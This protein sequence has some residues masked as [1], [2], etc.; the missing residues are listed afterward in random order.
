[1]KQLENNQLLMLSILM[2]SDY[3]KSGDTV[4]KIVCRIESDLNR[5]KSVNASRMKPSEWRRLVD[6][7]KNQSDLLLYSVQHLEGNFNS[8]KNVACFVDNPVNPQDVNIVF[9]GTHKKDELLDNGMGCYQTD[10]Q[11]QIE[12]AEYVNKLPENYG[13]N[14]TVTGHSKGG[15]KAQYVTVTTDRIGRCVPFDSQGFSKAFFEKY[16]DE[17]S[18]KSHCITA[19]NAADDYVNSI[20]IPIPCKRIFL[21]SNINY[22]YHFIEFHKPNIMLDEYGKLNP[23]QKRSK[24]SKQVSK[25]S[26]YL[27][28][29]RDKFGEDSDIDKLVVIV[30][31]ICS[32]HTKLSRH[33]FQPLWDFFIVFF[34][35]FVLFPI[36]MPACFFKGLRLVLSYVGANIK[37]LR[38]RRYNLDSSID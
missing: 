12:A 6:I 4:Q 9:R 37:F 7:I 25:Y 15:N 21:K 27:L 2:Y 36:K 28:S 3:I 33:F 30:E 24:F 35:L 14:M 22:V 19:I 8:G 29:N 34:G 23:V 18:K 10:T 13:N 1:M 20:F 26:A 16:A 31:K 5:G 17:I 11:K 38:Q 32:V